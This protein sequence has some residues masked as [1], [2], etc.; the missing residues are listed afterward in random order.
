MKHP[1]HRRQFLMTASA[2]IFGVPLAD[3]MRSVCHAASLPSEK[4]RA[5]ILIWLDGAPS[6]IDMWDPKPDAP[7]VIR[8]EFSAIQTSVPGVMFSEHLPKMAGMMD[9]CTLIRSMHHSIPEHG[10]AAQ[11][12][13]TGHPPSPALVYPSLGSVIARL[14]EDETSIPAYMAFNNPAA[15]GAGYLGSAW[16]AFELTSDVNALP[17]GLSLSADQDVDQFAK[18]L[19]LRDAF[20]R[21]LGDLEYDAT[22]SGLKRFQKNAVRTLQEDSLRKALDLSTEPPAIRERYGERSQLGQDLLRS[23]R[24]IEAGSRFV[25][26]GY[27]GWDTHTNNFTQ[28]RN[29][30]LP[31]LDAGFAA[32]TTDLQERGLLDSTIVC[33]GGEFGRTPNING[34]AGRDHWSRSFALLL[35]GAGLRPGMVHGATDDHGGEPVKDHCTPSDLIATLLTL[36]GNEY[37]GA[38]TS[39]SGRPM[40]LVKDGLPINAIRG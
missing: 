12:M 8:G 18:R 40:P 19:A 9:R 26:V 4:Q 39:P 1:L 7:D 6:T 10:P 14:S 24:L 22:A 16:N 30:L 27:S 33:C 11:Y 34:Q 32:L 31:Q 17:K 15:G 21:G 23:R 36:L 13:L 29:T 2:G 35:A 28:L 20:D 3:F 5:L 37:L 38:I 25:T